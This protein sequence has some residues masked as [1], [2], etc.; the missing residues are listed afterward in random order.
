MVPGYS[1]RVVAFLLHIVS[2]NQQWKIKIRMIRLINTCVTDIYFPGKIKVSFSLV[3]ASSL[4]LITL[5]SII[6]YKIDIW[7][8]YWAEHMQFWY[9]VWYSNVLH[10][11]KVKC[12][13]IIL[14]PLLKGPAISDLWDTST[15]HIYF[16]NPILLPGTRQARNCGNHYV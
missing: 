12:L 16:P 10:Q 1:H 4:P 14:S 5:P 8:R 13:F 11:I 6:I 9:F 7:D 2:L 3:Y 15:C